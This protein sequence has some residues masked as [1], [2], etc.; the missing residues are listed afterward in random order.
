MWFKVANFIV[1]Q[2]IPFLIAIAAITVFFGFFA[3]DVSLSFNSPQVIP[4][5]DPDYEAY[6]EFKKEFGEDGDLLIIGIQPNNV[7]RKDIYNAWAALTDKITTV[8]GV[9]GVNSITNIQT[10]EK[11]TA[12]TSFVRKR[13]FSGNLQSSRQADSLRLAMLDLPFYHNLFYNDTTQATFMAV[14]IEQEVLSTSRRVNVIDS[15]R[16]Y[17]EAFSKKHDLGLHYSGLPYIRTTFAQKIQKELNLFLLLSVAITSVILL[18][19]FRDIYAVIFPLILIGIIVVWTLGI[20]VILGYQLTILT[21]LVPPLIVIIAVPNFIYFLNRYHTEYRKHAN[22]LM[23]INRM[24]QHIAMVVLLNNV[25]TAIGFGVLYFVDSP[26][27]KEFGV[28]AFIVVIAIYCATLVLMPIV[29]SFL[30]TPSVKQTTY[31]DNRWMNKY[32][33]KINYIVQNKR[34]L[35]YITSVVIAGISVFG[36]LNLKAVGYILDDVPAHDKLY[37]DAMFFEKNFK[38][39][40]PFE[41][42]IDTRQQDG[43]KNVNIIKR[44]A[45]LQDS[46]E[47]RPEF[48]TTLSIADFV[49][50]A[51]QAYYNGS[52]S[53]FTMPTRDFGDMGLQAYLSNMQNSPDRAMSLSLVDTGY[54][55][56]RVSAKMADI[57]SVRLAVVMTELDTLT[58]SMFP[59]AE[60]GFTGYSRVFLKG[61]GYLLD[62]LISSLTAAIL[63]III[64]IIFMFRS[65]RLSMIVLIPNLLALLITGGIMGFFDI[66]L[67]PSTI[68]VFSIAF[69]IAVDA[70]FHFLARY[71]QDLKLH[72]WDIQHTVRISLEQTGF[73]VIF[74]SIVLIF[75]FGIF[76]FSDFGS[77]ISLGA[78]TAITVFSAMFTNIILIPALLLSFDRKKPREKK[79]TAPAEVVG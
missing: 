23:A 34:P 51:K 61:N 47:A 56:A 40:M 21:G 38:G 59:D 54:R 63:L 43:L 29:F 10:L 50:F 31:L 44:I 65:F 18:I 58:Q 41:I 36:M 24:V 78:L 25:T 70:S 53:K 66:H 13:F 11:D 26:I 12:N 7:F 4:L 15:V 8:G 32:L 69:G 46:I 28:V 19:F 2:R 71:R 45:D 60:I 48:G 77:T 6:R 35:V 75:G 1:R 33:D 52:P 37:K 73:S 49:K 39:I 27:L 22:K 68:L 20:I 42:T 55:K 14:R 16:L 9:R 5:S 72:N 3:K 17:T 76:C 57:G 74:T 79:N 67:K 64:L 30:P 62:S